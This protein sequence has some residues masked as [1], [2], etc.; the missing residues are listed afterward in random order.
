MVLTAAIG[1]LLLNGCFGKTDKVFDTVT[2]HRDVVPFASAEFGINSGS[3]VRITLR[4]SNEFVRQ[5]ANE[6]KQRFARR[7]VT[8]IETGMP[9]YWLLLDGAFDFFSDTAETSRLNRHVYTQILKKSQK[10]KFRTRVVNH[11]KMTSREGTVIC[12]DEEL[13]PQIYY[14]DSSYSAAGMFC[15]ISLYRTKDLDML[16]AIGLF[17]KKT[18]AQITGPDAFYPEMLGDSVNFAA[19][20]LLK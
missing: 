4:N 3:T 7:N 13:H 12:S 6:I 20:G 19:S 2:L 1:S 11:Y 5:T 18:V 16:T 14:R 8:V 9:D 15:H 17:R 10:V